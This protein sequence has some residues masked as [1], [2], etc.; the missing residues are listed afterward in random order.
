MRAIVQRVSRASVRIGAL[1]EA[2]PV[3]RS[4]TSERVCEPR[5]DS[6]D[7]PER[8]GE[9]CLN[10]RLADSAAP[11]SCVKNRVVAAIGGGFVVLLGVGRDD[12]EADADFLVDRILGLRVFADTAATLAERGCR[13][14]RA[15]E[16]A[17]C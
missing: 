12:S 9:S 10:P 7:A 16:S 8:A 2:P 17:S 13:A 4:G 6:E 15:S 3:E 14:Q 1:A 5:S 11:W